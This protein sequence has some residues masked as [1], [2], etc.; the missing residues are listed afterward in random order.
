[1]LLLTFVTSVL[2]QIT[3]QCTNNV[4]VV[5]FRV[6]SYFVFCEALELVLAVK[7]EL[8]LENYRVPNGISLKLESENLC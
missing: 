7:P 5:K 6:F 1:M 3:L 8:S 4:V 2:N